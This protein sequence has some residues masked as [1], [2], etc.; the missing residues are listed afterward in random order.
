VNELQML[1][2]SK[3]HTLLTKAEMKRAK[4]VNE[5]IEAGRG[6]ETFNETIENARKNPDDALAKRYVEACD[7][8]AT[9]D[10]EASR[11]WGPDGMWVLRYGPDR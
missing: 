5:L 6:Y 1:T 11:R 7:E 9:I 4:V 8:I 10:R 3:L 2:K